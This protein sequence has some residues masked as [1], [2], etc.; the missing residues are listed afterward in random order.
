LLPRMH[1]SNRTLALKH[2]A[3][4]ERSTVYSKEK[5]VSIYQQG[6]AGLAR[7]DKESFVRHELALATRNRSAGSERSHNTIQ[8][9]HRF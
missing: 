6:S 3:C 1:H 2:A 7:N 4:S 8:K 5:F 9:H